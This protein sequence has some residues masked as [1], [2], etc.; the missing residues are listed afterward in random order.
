MTLIELII[1]LALVSI[2]VLGLSSINLFSHFHVINADRRANLQNEASIALEDM[3]KEIGKAIGSTVI[4][5]ENPI[6][7][8]PIS[9]DTSIRAFVDLA[10]DGVSPGDGQRNTQGDRWRAYRLRPSTAP[11]NERN[12]IWYYSNYTGA[13]SSY[14]V[15]ARQIASIA[16]TVINNNVSVTITACWD[17]AVAESVDNP[18]VE[19]NAGIQMPSVST[20]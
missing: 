3:G 6:D 17:P 9:A 10:A 12:Q 14:E 19:M 20:N 8:S 13:G 16:Y 18:C 15:V 4:A 5:G 11:V 1:A 7:L 2:I